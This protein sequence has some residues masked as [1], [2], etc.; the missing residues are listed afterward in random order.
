MKKMN[1]APSPLGLL[2]RKALTEIQPNIESSRFLLGPPLELRSISKDFLDCAPTQVMKENQNGHREE[3]SSFPSTSADLESAPVCPLG[4]NARLTGCS[5]R[6]GGT[7][8]LSQTFDEAMLQEIDALC[9]QRSSGREEDLQT[10]NLPAPKTVAASVPDALQLPGDS[11]APM[12][13]GNEVVPGL[14]DGAEMAPKEVSSVS[15]SDSLHRKGVNP[16]DTPQISTP[17]SEVLRRS[18]SPLTENSNLQSQLMIGSANGITGGQLNASG[19]DD[20]RAS[21]PGSSTL[22]QSVPAHLQKLNSSQRDAATSD[23][24][25]PL[26]ILAGPG[27]GKV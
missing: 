22:N 16:R 2:Q 26:L 5:G 19:R 27:S 25:K 13:E 10:A 4:A 21:T 23:T 11:S 20:P 1:N 24:T 14:P 18:Q 15:P 9:Q 8:A 6:D 12:T 17:V 7:D 3:Q